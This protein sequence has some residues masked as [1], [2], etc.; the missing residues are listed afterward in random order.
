M[1]QVHQFTFN[2]FAENTFILFDETKKCIIIDPGC[3]SNDERIILSRFI[4]DNALEPVRLINTHCHIDHVFGNRYVAEL[5]NLPLEIH[6]NEIPVLEAQSTVAQ[7]YGIPDV[8]QS[9]DPSIFIEDHDIIQFGNSTLKVL[10]TPGHSPGSISFYSEE[11]Q[12]IIS[13]DVLF[14]SSIGRTDLPGGDYNTLME[15]IFEK[16]MPLE[17]SVIVY[18]GH[19]DSTS[20]GVER[21]TNPFILNHTQA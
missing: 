9:P 5:Y 2:P 16:L 20:I 8:Q 3:Y 19:G 4:Q 11:N 10:L 15:S 13:G 12:F 7:M 18:S 6:K 14:Q 1:I 21:K 17:D